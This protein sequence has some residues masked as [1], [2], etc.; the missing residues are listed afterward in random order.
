MSITLTDQQAEALE[1]IAAET[2]ATKQSMIS[3]SSSLNSRNK[4]VCF[5]AF[6]SESQRMI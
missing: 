2:G 3:F 6:V 4:A 5:S 1:R